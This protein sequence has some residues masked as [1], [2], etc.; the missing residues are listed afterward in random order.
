MGADWVSVLVLEG[1]NSAV[2]FDDPLCF[3]RLGRLVVSTRGLYDDLVGLV[4]L[5]HDDGSGVTSVRAEQMV[6]VEQDR[7]ARAATQI[8]VE[9][10]V[11]HQRLVALL[12]AIA[13]RRLDIELGLVQVL[14]DVRG[15]VRLDQRRY[16]LAVLPVAVAYTKIM[17]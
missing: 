6:A 15:Q 9:L 7:A 12:E 14:L 5:A 17:H 13:Q 8:H 16:V 11:L 10:L 4:A 2:P 3:V 1:F